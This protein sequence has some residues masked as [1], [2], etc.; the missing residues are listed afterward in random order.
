[1]GKGKYI[2]CL[3]KE[4]TQLLELKSGTGLCNVAMD[5]EGILFRGIK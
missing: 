2:I 3:I 4:S 5:A 1:M